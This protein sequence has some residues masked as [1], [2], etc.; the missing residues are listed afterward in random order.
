MAEKSKFLL[1][2]GAVCVLALTACGNGGGGN[3]GEE[4][5]SPTP[6]VAPDDYTVDTAES[7]LASATV[8]GEEVSDVVSLREGMQDSGAQDASSMMAAMMELIDSDP[9]ECKDPVITAVTAGALNGEG[10]TEH[11]NDMVGGTGP[12]DE[13]ISVRVMDSRDAADQAVKDLKSSLD[14]CQEFTLSSMGDG[15]TVNSSTSSPEVEGAGETL[16]FSGTGTNEDS[17]AS[18]D[19][20]GE[21][22]FST[23]AMSVGNMVVM[24]VP[25]TGAAVVGGGSS[26]P[27]ASP[28]SEDELQ[29]SMSDLAQAFVDGPVEPTE[30]ASPGDTASP[31]A[32]PTES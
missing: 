6:V 5:P 12:N 4:S 13:T 10:V 32:S 18:P 29:S 21:N 9:A 19:A 22:T 17:T 31:T 14:D 24:V 23:S 25:G 30:S 2:T 28:A 3:G 1:A 8:D 15:T 16:V 27:T 7:T 26:S 11:T 20:E